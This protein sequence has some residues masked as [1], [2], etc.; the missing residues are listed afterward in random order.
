LSYWYGYSKAKALP[1]YTL[2][3]DFELNL[4]VFSFKMISDSLFDRNIMYDN[5]KNNVSKIKN[6]PVS[7]TFFFIF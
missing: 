4:I 5:V 6:I 2:M 1:L 3:C 7:F